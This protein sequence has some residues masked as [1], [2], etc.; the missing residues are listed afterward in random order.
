MPLRTALK[1][2]KLI[3]ALLTTAENEARTTGDAEPGA[4]HLL[5]ASLVVDD[6]SA[7]TALGID[8]AAARRALADVHREALAALGIESDSTDPLPA[9]SGLY[10]AETSL[11]EAL[12]RT[13]VI[14]KHS[15]T[16]LRS[17]HALIAVAEREHGTSARLL[18]RLG[19]DREQL[20]AAATAALT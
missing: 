19:V 4:E 6:D 12:R 5:I 9:A 16:G 7:R 14:A 10:R 11:Q 3:A 17:A 18:M 1:D 20:I 15:P 2:T 8:A 13:G